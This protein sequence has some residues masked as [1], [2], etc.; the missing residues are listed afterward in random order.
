M[1]LARMAVSIAE[2]ASGQELPRLCLLNLNAPGIPCSQWK[3]LR[4]APLSDAFFL[5]TY[6]KRVSPRGHA[7]FWLEDGFKIEPHQPGTDMALLAQGHPVLTLLGPN[8]D[9]NGWIA[10]HLQDIEG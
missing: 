2:R 9:D 10:D 8:R 3:K 4:A 6:E 5:D 7:Y 1:R